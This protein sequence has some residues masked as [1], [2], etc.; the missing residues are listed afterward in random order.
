[1]KPSLALILGNNFG[2]GKLI[3]VKTGFV[4]TFGPYRSRYLRIS[5]AASQIE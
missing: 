2:N 3:A 1:M 5:L 4:L